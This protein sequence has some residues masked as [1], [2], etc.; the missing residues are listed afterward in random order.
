LLIQQPNNDNPSQSHK[1]ALSID[2]DFLKAVLPLLPLRES[3]PKP[4][5]HD[6]ITRRANLKHIF[7]ILFENIP[8]E[9]DV[10]TDKLTFKS[11]DGAELTM[12]HIHHVSLANAKDTPPTPAIIHV[13][14]GGMIAMSSADMAPFVVQQVKRLKVP[15]FSVDYR[16]APEHPDPAATEDVFAALQYVQR[17]AA[18]FNVDPARLAIMGESSGGGVAAGVALLARDRAMNPPLAKQILIYPMLD[19]RN[20]VPDENLV[21]FA[22][23]WD[24]ESNVTG[25]TAYLG[26]ERAGKPEAEVSHYAAPA[27]AKDLKGLPRTYLDVSGLDIFRDE[28]VDYAARLA[29]AGVSLEFHLWEGVPHSFEG[30][31]PSIPVSVAATAR[32]DLAMASI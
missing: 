28:C 25:W 6:I 7:S 4:G 5:L 20:L 14:G 8:S 26:A 31:A 10:I 22:Q 9:P 21:P 23:A 32:R 12:L 16:L 13:H 27:R 17:H 24:Y 15:M 3:L 29:K 30:S 19:D 11:Y 1:M 18:D 2:P